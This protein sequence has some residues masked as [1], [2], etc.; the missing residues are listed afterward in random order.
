MSDPASQHEALKRWRKVLRPRRVDI[1]GDFAGKELFGIH[2]EA[3]IAHCLTQAEVDYDGG[4]QMLHAVHAV[5]SFLSNLQQRGCS[6][7]I[8]WFD[9]YE[10]LSAPSASRANLHKYV[11]TRTVLKEHLRHVPETAGNETDDRGPRPDRGINFDFSSPSSSAFQTYASQNPL[12][13]ILC[14]GDPEDDCS[15]DGLA[16][17]SHFAWMGY[18]L[19]FFN[20]FEFKSSKVHVNIAT[21]PPSSSIPIRESEDPQTDT[22]DDDLSSLME[23][24]EQHSLKAG[25]ELSI[26]D[27]VALVACA[28]IL[29]ETPTTESK[30]HAAAIMAHNELLSHTTLTQR[31][32]D[33][34]ENLSNS[35]KDLFLKRYAEIAN[36][37]IIIMSKTH[38]LE[39]PDKDLF[40]LVDG[41]L[42]R[43]LTLRISCSSG[44]KFTIPHWNLLDDLVDS[45]TLRDLPDLYRQEPT[46]GTMDSSHKS[47]DL[48]EKVHAV[49]PFSHPVLDKYLDDVRLDTDT[50]REPN[51]NSRIFQELTHWHN[52]KRP[53]DP[54]KQ[55]QQPPGFWARKRNQKLMAD[56][57]AYS[58][59]L[60]NSSGKNI[61]PEIVVVQNPNRS[62]ATAKVVKQKQPQKPTKAGKK[63]SG[64]QAALDAAKEKQV[65]RSQSKASNVVRFW[66]DQCRS[67]E[68]ERTPVQR[69]AKAVKYLLDLS[70]TDAET[71]GNEVLLYL[72]QC[73]NLVRKSFKNPA[74]VYGLNV[75]ALAWS[76][77]L[78]MRKLPMNNIVFKH[79]ELIASGLRLSLGSPSGPAGTRKLPWSV[80][81]NKTEW[82][83]PIPAAEF[84]LEHCG[85]YL[86][87]SF[88]SA[89][90]ARV[91]FNPDAW[92]RKVLDAIDDNSSLFVVA[93][94]SAGKTFISFYAMKKALQDSDDDVLVYVAPTKALVNQIAAEI[95]ARFT[96][97][98]K[99]DGRSVWA[100]HTRDYRIN[101]PTGCQVLVTVPHI[102]QIMLLAPSNA[103]KE[104]SWAR[105]VKR[106]I[107][108]EVHCIGQADDGII[109]EQLLLMAPCP[110][111]ALSATVGNPLEFKEW[112]SGTQKAKGFELVMVTHSARYAD[113]RKF[114]YV[115]PQ[116]FNFEGH[117]PVERLPLQGLDAEGASPKFVFVHPVTTINSKDAGKLEDMSL[118]PRDC[119]Q[120]WRAMESSESEAFPLKTKLIAQPSQNG[121]MKSDVLAWEAKLKQQLHSWMTHP[122]S[123]FSRCQEIL[124]SKAPKEDVNRKTGDTALQLLVD[125]RSHGA[126]P[127]I[128]F[129]F[130]RDECET[131]LQSVQ[132]VLE[133]AEEKYRETSS[134][135]KRKIAEYEKWKKAAAKFRPVKSTSQPGMSKTE[136]A[137][138][139][140]SQESSSFAAFS[141]DEPI[142]DFSF[143]DMTKI[144]R[145]ELDRLLAPLQGRVAD[146]FITGIRRGL[147]VHHSGMNRK[148]RQVI[149]VLF[150]RSVLTVVIATGTLALGINM[151]C[152]TVAFTGDSV[153]LTALNYRQASGRAGRRGFDLLGN[154]VFH[155]IPQHRAMEIMSARLPDLR[156][157]FPISVTLILRLFGLLHG[158]D[159]SDY[160]VKMIE[161]IFTQTRL[162]LGGPASRMSTTHHLRFSIEYLRRQNLLSSNGHPLG[163]AGLVGHLY[164]T[165]N[166]VFAF[167]S[168][169][170]EGYFHDLCEDINN[171]GK[172]SEIILTLVH[173]L[174]HLFC[175]IPVPHYA[176][177]A[178][179]EEV[180]N[181]SP[182]III[183]PEL[184]QKAKDILHAH[185]KET[186]DIFASYIHTYSKQHLQDSID[187]ELP[188][189]KRRAA[190]EHATG[191][192]EFG[193]PTLPT[194][195]IRSPFAALSGHTDEFKNVHD[196]VATAR[197]GVFLDESAV[198]YIPIY[199][200]ETNNVPFNAYIL[201]FFKHGDLQALIRDNGIKRGD[202]WFRLKDFSLVVATL[203]ASFESLLRTDAEFDDSTM[204]DIQDDGGIEESL[205]DDQA[206]STEKSTDGH[207]GNGIVNGSSILR[208]YRALKLL[209]EEFDEKFKK[210]WA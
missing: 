184:P 55:V 37:I 20:N 141:P 75:L 140:A 146:H 169:L 157:T 143:A 153:F 196:L 92:Q 85:P 160:A 133:K 150:R 90:D 87:R 3:L 128:L 44:K 110:I 68:T 187:N 50:A 158:T 79:A 204:A 66:D 202:V 86:E 94:T 53:I 46:G 99:H 9:D 192:N 16:I 149:E 1:V 64:K 38:R 138:E 112:L 127:A 130:D 14:S 13:F 67:F 71:V 163:F 155:G 70:A 10:T 161:S 27:Q 17:M 96:K 148:Y 107:F 51:S 30:M 103:K 11:L 195:V 181:P 136:L 97:S 101:N 117:K 120:L 7:H 126:L 208:V 15:A 200:D 29:S 40:D 115:P 147:G 206:A 189:T 45:S 114:L 89:P 108:D 106:I 21:S 56:T 24:L 60:T 18:T 156:G 78:E 172:R 180:V 203:I 185:N 132:S 65:E 131:T 171:E 183:L 135:W 77:V 197:A 191:L 76:H 111:I 43:H 73:L 39:G 139:Q 26:R 33:E 69:Y 165:E 168:L 57:I 193:I 207:V 137:R 91:T 81:V 95:Q 102:L 74:S 173:V 62:G 174:C 164:F 194:P 41:R 82:D 12:H 32:Y 52:A 36:Q 123:P 83:L 176:N 205:D 121:L 201:D 59:S 199:P 104:N 122:E 151:P 116:E 167:H 124:A 48:V 210:V 118:E 8:L 6:F 209:N 129:N 4:F 178:W 54:K 34:P 61:V 188:F 88:D 154:V 28:A 19:G 159:D 84:Q 134:A 179:L 198:P 109:W 182:S 105:R 93:P 35:P 166:A 63:P 5:E 145:D 80:S 125:L 162:F 72:C 186:L 177:K 23:R 119:L 113:L 190:P 31:S 25:L 170:K 49:L 22:P 144:S 58:A 142:P 175:R 47:V 2:G 42:F 100:I 98:Y 152:K